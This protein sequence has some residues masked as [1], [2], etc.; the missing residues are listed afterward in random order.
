M[1]FDG[2]LY[3][4]NTHWQFMIIKDN[5]NVHEDVY[6]YLSLSQKV[7]FTQMNAKKGVKIFGERAIADIF[8]EYKHVDDGLM[9]SKPVVAHFYPDGLTPLDKKK[10]VEAVNLI[11]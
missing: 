6:T 1:I 9:P 2:K 5:Y 3:S 4:H 8:K 10:I 7:I 11:N